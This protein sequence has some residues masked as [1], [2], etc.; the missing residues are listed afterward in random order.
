MLPA[1]ILV[2]EDEKTTQRIVG[3]MLSHMGHKVW[4]VDTGEHGMDVF[5]QGLFD[6]VLSDVN[7]PG[8]D[9]IDAI[10]HMRVSDPTMIPIVMTS[11]R[12]QETAVRALECGVRRFLMK[13]FSLEDLKSKIDQALDERRR[14]VETRL[15]VGDLIRTRS[16]LQHKVVTQERTLTRTEQYLNYLLDAAP[17]GI[18]STDKE[19]RVLTFNGVAEQMYGYLHDDVVGRHVSTVTG[20]DAN[21][22]TGVPAGD[23]PTERKGHHSR[24]GDEPF[25]VL[26]RSRG[27]LDGRGECIAWLYVMED[28]SER[29]NMETQL[30]YAERLSLLGQLAPRVAHEFKTPLQLI[31][32]HAELALQW[33]EDG[34]VA[35]AR[36]SVE[37]IL[38]AVQKMMVLVRQMSN[39]GKPSEGATAALD[40]R[41]EL[42]K[43]LT[44]LRD[45]GAV[46]YCEVVEQFDDVLP[47]VPGDPA[48]I[49]QV[50]R[51]LIVNAAQAMEETRKRVLTLG[52]R[53]SADDMYVEAGIQDTGP[54]VPEEYLSQIFNPFFTTK[55]EGKGTGLGLSIVKTVLDRHGASIEVESRVGEGTRFAIRFPALREE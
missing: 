50:F 48:Q 22:Y 40:L 45:L 20:E 18:M 9:G 36:T 31:S 11:R 30:L 10:R 16:D 42:E 54:G 3:D 51:N 49:E 8:M 2:V 21:F 5:A 32:G 29:E 7:L 38:P 35:D 44:P 46:K 14:I 34:Q 13:P 6:V 37:S 24:R 27:I 23:A 4:C 15:L 41:A 26:V 33:L 52:L 19:G 1:N 25:P 55:P 43:T 53:A 28:L 47:R 17:F 39:L 12:D